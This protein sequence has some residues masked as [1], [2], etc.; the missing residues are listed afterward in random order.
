MTRKSHRET[1]SRAH[2]KH[3][4]THSTLVFGNR[5]KVNDPGFQVPDHEQGPPTA[6]D[7][8]PHRYHH[9]SGLR[10]EPK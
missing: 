8:T 4:A 3:V 2:I 9:R 10:R 5:L 6:E 7:P 1:G